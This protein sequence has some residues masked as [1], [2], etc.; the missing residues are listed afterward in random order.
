MHLGDTVPPS[1]VS[2]LNPVRQTTDT[3]ELA[4]NGQPGNWSKMA[5]MYR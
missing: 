3:E 4:N 5:A 2:D 1:G